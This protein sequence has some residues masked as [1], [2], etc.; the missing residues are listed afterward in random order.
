MI[1]RVLPSFHNNAFLF[2]HIVE[3]LGA[4]DPSHSY[5]FVALRMTHCLL[6]LLHHELIIDSF[7]CFWSIR[8]PLL[9]VGEDLVE[10][11]IEVGVTK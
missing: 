3:E 9:A 11:G 7:R 6:D 2:Q 4:M 10:L 8:W 1:A 5:S